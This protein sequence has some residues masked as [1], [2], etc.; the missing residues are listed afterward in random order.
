MF[1]SPEEAIT[2]CPPPSRR[3]G[4][5]LPDGTRP[6]DCAAALTA[7]RPFLEGDPPAVVG[8]GLHRKMR[9]SELP[10]SPFPLLQHDPDD[11]VPTL[12]IKGIPGGIFR[13]L[14]EKDAL[15]SIGAVELHQYAGYSGGHKGVAVGCGARNTLD[16]LH[17][18]DL[19]TAGGVEI[20]RLEGNPFRELVDLLGEAARCRWAL[21]QTAGGWLA[22]EPRWV[23][24]RAAASLDC[25]EEHPERYPAMILDVPV[26]KAVNFYQASRAATY[27]GLSPAPPLQ[28]GATL[29]LEAPCPEGMGTGSGERAFAELLRQGRAPW[30]ELLE[31]P[32]PVGAGTQRALVLALLLQHYSLVICGVQDPEALRACGL[33]ATSLPAAALAP[34]GT[35]R[36]RDPFHRL[37]IL[38]GGQGVP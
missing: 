7:L 14:S 16:A 31:G 3:V 29:Y 37:P 28:E 22:G 32:A 17:H 9:T 19:V 13:K 18:R 23:L 21:V 36:L 2:A 20:G 11:T 38:T 6:V 5:A 8:L 10:A 26:R 15:L 27:V 33:N 4:I 24:Q 12:N 35:F 34:P 1:L 30:R 25:W